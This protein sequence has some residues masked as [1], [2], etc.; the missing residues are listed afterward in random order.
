MMT[1]NIDIYIKELKDFLIFTEENIYCFS[2]FN[3]EGLKNTD[4]YGKHSPYRD[5]SSDRHD[6]SSRL[7]RIIYYILWGNHK[8][9][10]YGLPNLYDA[11]RINGGS[12]DVGEDKYGCDTLITTEIFNGDKT[13]G[14]FIILPKGKVKY[15][16]KTT[17]LNQY[18]GVGS[19]HKDDFR[20]FMNIIKDL[21]E[22]N[23]IDDI[24]QELF[25]KNETFFSKI[26]NFSNFI[27][28]FMLEGWDELNAEDFVK[29][30]SK[31]ICERLNIFF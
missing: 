21:Y 27:S 14:N 30:R 11:E 20:K 9:N 16:L 28:Y 1:D 18:R 7:A 25:K 12:F 17:T 3:F 24:W 22:G 31:K 26:G 13:I 6:D 23:A 8:Y 19:G 4:K 10:E 2:T 5:Y 15:C 29:Q